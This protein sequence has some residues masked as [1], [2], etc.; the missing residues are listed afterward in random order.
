M[1]TVLARCCGNAIPFAASQPSQ[2]AAKSVNGPGS[3][4]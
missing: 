1:K 2:C 4:A 3:G